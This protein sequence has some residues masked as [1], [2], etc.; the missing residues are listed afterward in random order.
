MRVIWTEQAFARLAA[1]EDFVAQRDAG[2]AERL[3]ARIVARGER[4]AQFPRAGRRLRDW[5]EEDLREVLVGA[6]RV[7]YRL[8]DEQLAIL[9]VFEG[10]RL[11]RAGELAPNEE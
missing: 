8:G 3:V 10:H 7:V 4:L 1:I 11:L 5:P 6:F 2:A 9:T